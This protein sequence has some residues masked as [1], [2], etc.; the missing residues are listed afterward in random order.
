MLSPRRVSPNVK[1]ILLVS[2]LNANV[3]S[4]AF[5]PFISVIFSR[6]PSDFAYTKIFAFVFSFTFITIL[7]IFSYSPKST[8]KYSPLRTSDAKYVSALPSNA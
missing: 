8:S 1:Q 3:F 2:Q 5:N 7:E 6:A 4:P